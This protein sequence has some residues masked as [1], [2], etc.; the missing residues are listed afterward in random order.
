MGKAY[1]FYPPSHDLTKLMPFVILRPLCT[2]ISMHKYF[3]IKGQ[4]WCR[5]KIIFVPPL[6]AGSSSQGKGPRQALWWSKCL[7]TKGRPSSGRS[8]AP[9]GQVQVLFLH[10]PNVSHKLFTL[11]KTQSSASLFR[12]GSRNILQTKSILL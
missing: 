11:A 5:A 3:K 9:I 1:F 4:Y 10:N 6:R 8:G 7:N 2:Y 12:G